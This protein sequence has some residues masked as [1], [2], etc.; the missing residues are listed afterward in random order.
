[1]I[2]V[3]QAQIDLDSCLS[4]LENMNLLDNNADKIVLT[5]IMIDYI[6]ENIESC[7]KGKLISTISEYYEKLLTKF[8]RVNSKLSINDDVF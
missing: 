1:M 4:I 2:K 5:P 3:W 7:S 8:Y 6:N